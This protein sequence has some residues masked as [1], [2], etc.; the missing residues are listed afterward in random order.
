MHRRLIHLM[1]VLALLLPSLLTAQNPAAPAAG[2]PAAGAQAPGGR[3]GRGGPA[4]PANQPAPRD[5]D[6]H[7]SFVAIAQQGNV[8]LLFVGD[9]ITDWFSN[10]RGG[11]PAT[12]LEVWNAN[13][14]AFKPANFGIAG[15]TTQGVLWRMQNGELEGFKARLIVLMLGTNNINRNP[16]DEIVDG[17]RLIIEEFKKRQPQAKVLVLGVFPRNADPASPL[18]ATIKEMN[19]KLA[20][21]AD[22]KQVFFKDIGEKFLTPDGTLTQEIMPDGLHPSAKGYQVWADAIIGDVK[23]LMK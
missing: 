19:G 16:V 3:G 12:G 22:N 4:L 14:G 21:L 10:P 6:R 13:F 11:Q 20:K 5:N 1:A 9:S 15:D 2:A 17:N 18:R 23:T 8:D 7:K